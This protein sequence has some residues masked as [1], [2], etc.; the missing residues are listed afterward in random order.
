MKPTQRCEKKE[1]ND[2]Y[3]GSLLLYSLDLTEKAKA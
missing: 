1:H 3:S 2:Y